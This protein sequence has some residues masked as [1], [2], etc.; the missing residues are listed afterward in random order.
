MRTV[1]G[2]IGSPRRLG[3]SEVLVKEIAARIEPAVDLQL[4]RLTDLDL[5]P[6]RGCY[7][8]L[9]KGGECVIKDDVGQV[10]DALCRADGVILAAP[11][12]FLGAYGVV[13]TLVDRSN[14]LLPRAEETDGKPALV[15]TLAGVTGRDGR[16]PADLCGAALTLGLTIKAQRTVF[17]ALPGEVFLAG[18]NLDAAQEMARAL[19]E[20]TAEPAAALGTCP[21]C[22]ANAFA[23]IEAGVKCL[24]C[25]GRGQLEMTADGPRLSIEADA[26]GFL[27]GKEWR[28]RHADWLLGMKARFMEHKK[29]LKEI[30]LEYRHQ[31]QWLGK[32]DQ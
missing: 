12:Y 5:K 6:C 25:Q 32:Q 26:E 11:T 10:F 28:L 20:P 18:Q 3:N 17:A 27:S 19:F 1:L 13:K 8:C 15:L 4:V 22:G 23:F 2:L 29:E 7:Q 31:G 16:A 30:V 21:V 24:V 9:E 14:M